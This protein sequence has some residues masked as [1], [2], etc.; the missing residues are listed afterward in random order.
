MTI[1]DWTQGSEAIV[2]QT[3]RSCTAVWYFRRTFCPRCGC[4]HPVARQASGRGVAHAV[5]LVTR[6]PSEELRAH[7]PYA[8]ALIDADEGFRM[9]AHAA[10]DVAIG[11]RVQC[12]FTQIA[13]RLVPRFERTPT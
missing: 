4:D 10:S 9:M 8:I 12:T 2:Y 3:C 5:T 1:A 11:D 6:A 13:G 7:A